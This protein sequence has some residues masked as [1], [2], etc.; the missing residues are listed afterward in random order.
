MDLDDS[1]LLQRTEPPISTVSHRWN[2]MPILEPELE[3]LF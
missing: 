2:K 3:D 1:T